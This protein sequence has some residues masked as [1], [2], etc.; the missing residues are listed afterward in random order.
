MKAYKAIINEDE[1]K[2]RLISSPR[3]DGEGT[4]PPKILNYN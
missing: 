4:E 3:S 1:S 2:A